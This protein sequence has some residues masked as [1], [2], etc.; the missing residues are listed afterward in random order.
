MTPLLLLA[1]SLLSADEIPL[2]PGVAPGS[3]NWNWAE[4]MVP[5]TDDKRR[6]RN[7]TKPT[8]TVYPA[9]NPNGT[10]IVVCPGGGF[11]H[12]AIDHEGHE[13]ARWLNSLG[14]T[15]FVLKYRLMRTADPAA[16]DTAV[17]A[18]R[19]VEAIP[20][21]SADGRE[22]V[23][24][25][26]RR[27]TEF[28]VRPDRIGILGFSAGG[29]VAAAAALTHDD[30]SRPDFAAPI[31][32]AVPPDAKAPAQPMPLFLVHAHDDK[33]VDAWQNS[34]RL[35]GLWKATGAPAE[36]H[37]YSQGGHG[38]GMRP[39]HKPVDQW[40]IRLKEWLA[41]PGPAALRRLLKASSRR[42]TR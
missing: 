28:K 34:A 14:V 10:A 24:L 25:V 36:L 37:I 31:Y 1:A 6:V 20:L 26:R 30:Q 39:Q 3:E 19:R 9:A 21:A 38:F 7:V 22:A 13:V 2:Y 35:Y 41:A 32:P 42:R 18:K 5:P 40:T 16:G 29:W 11:R 12:L 23:R 15:A 33:T 17:L 8:L 4:D 27:A